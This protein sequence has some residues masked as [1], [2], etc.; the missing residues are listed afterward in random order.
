MAVTEVVKAG[1]EVPS[2]LSVEGAETKPAQKEQGYDLAQEN[3]T[4]PKSHKS[5]T[6]KV[7]KSI[8]HRNQEDDIEFEDLTPRERDALFITMMLDPLGLTHDPGIPSTTTEAYDYFKGKQT[9]G[10]IVAALGTL[11]TTLGAG[12]CAKFAHGIATM[13]WDQYMDKLAEIP[14]KYPASTVPVFALG[15]LVFG[16]YWLI[17]GLTSSYRAGKQLD[18]LEERLIEKLK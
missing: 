1:K 14:S 8:K 12:A 2:Y 7:K 4:G 15:V 17:S 16:A 9:V 5:G 3:I 11:G 10:R 13:G 6:A 18:K